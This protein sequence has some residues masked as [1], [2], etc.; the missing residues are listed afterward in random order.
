METR[1]CAMKTWIEVHGDQDLGFLGQ[2]PDGQDADP[3][4]QGLGFRH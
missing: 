4:G 1:N 3:G 2:G